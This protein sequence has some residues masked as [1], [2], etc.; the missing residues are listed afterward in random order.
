MKVTNTTLILST[1]CLLIS[2]TTPVLAQTLCSHAIVED[3]KIH[4]GNAYVKQFGAPWRMLGNPRD[5]GVMPMYKTVL[6]HRFSGE[7]LQFGFP[8]NYDCAI[9]DIH[10]LQPAISM[11]TDRSPINELSKSVFVHN[12]LSTAYSARSKKTIYSDS[13]HTLSISPACNAPRVRV[14]FYN[15]AWDLTMKV[16][17]QLQYP[18]NNAHGETGGELLIE[19]GLMEDGKWIIEIK[20]ISYSRP[21]TY[22]YQV[23][24]DC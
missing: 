23:K 16:K 9:T 5:V 8:D 2:F 15:L 18:P 4:N 7:A 24:V 13:I 3:V 21:E 6:N 12:N 22:E 11:N 10:L 19:R 14:R 17:G 20:N 1:F